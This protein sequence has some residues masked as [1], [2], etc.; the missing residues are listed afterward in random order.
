M[1][2]QEITNKIITLAE[3][4]KAFDLVFDGGDGDS[5][6]TTKIYQEIDDILYSPELV[7]IVDPHKIRKRVQIAKKYH[8]DRVANFREGMV[9]VQK[10]NK[11]VFVS[12]IGEEL[13]WEFD[14]ARDFHEGIALVRVNETWYFIDK[15][16]R[17]ITEEGFDRACEF[18]EGLA[19][20]SKEG[21]WY[22]I[23]QD[24]QTLGLHRFRS[25]GSFSCGFASVSDEAGESYLTSAGTLSG[26]GPYGR[27]RTFH[28]G[29]AGV[30][31]D[32]LWHFI[33]Q[34]G[35]EISVRGIMDPII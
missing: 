11:V 18:Q 12:D 9:V 32:G 24:G 28:E 27:A 29:I 35:A 13:P 1:D 14:S 26:F 34:S 5:V 21:Q 7:G 10:G 30:Y 17:K 2:C 8:L 22:F 19:S 23:N 6:A 15:T 4:A 16:G 25:C 33:N 3:R 20:V 31:H